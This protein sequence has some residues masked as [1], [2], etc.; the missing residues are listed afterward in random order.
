MAVAHETRGAAAVVELPATDIEAHVPF[1]MLRCLFTLVAVGLVATDT[2]RAGLALRSFYESMFVRVEP[3]RYVH[4]GPYE[5]SVVHIDRGRDGGFPG[6]AWSFDTAGNIV[7]R[8]V[9]SAPLWV[10]KFD[11]TSIVLRAVARE[12]QVTSV[13]RCVHYETACDAQTLPLPVVFKMLDDL[14]T[15]IGSHSLTSILRGTAQGYIWLRLAML[16][17]G[18]YIGRASEPQLRGLGTIEIK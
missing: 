8:S 7:E 10:Y 3:D 12:L 15:A 13:P 5:Y 16:V 9:S 18:C 11:T 1:S 2:P 6:S 4:F 14:M 17:F